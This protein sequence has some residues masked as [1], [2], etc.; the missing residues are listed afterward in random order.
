MEPP[1]AAPAVVDVQTIMREVRKEARVGIR[2][3]DEL[4]RAARRTIPAHLPAVLARLRASTTALEE[5]VAKLGDVPP[6]PPTLRAQ[7]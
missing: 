4:A 2:A 6:G 3:Q 7:A 5:A 1:F